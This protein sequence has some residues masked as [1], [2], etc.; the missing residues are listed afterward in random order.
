ME[1]TLCSFESALPCEVTVDEDNGRYMIK[2]AD[3][4]GE[5]FNNA[6]DLI[7]WVHENWSSEEFCNPIEFTEMIEK[8][9]NY[10]KYG[11]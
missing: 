9:N 2:K 4:S 3:S 8:L 1:F 11:D 5:V 7:K 6:D 10:K